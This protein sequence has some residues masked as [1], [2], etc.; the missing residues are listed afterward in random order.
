[1]LKCFEAGTDFPRYTHLQ[2][3]I[4]SDWLKALILVY[5]FL[6]QQHIAWS[7]FFFSLHSIGWLV[8]G[9]NGAEAPVAPWSVFILYM[10]RTDEGLESNVLI[11]PIKFLPELILVCFQWQHFFSPLN[12]FWLWFFFITRHDLDG[13]IQLRRF[14]DEGIRVDVPAILFEFCLSR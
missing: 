13:R 7:L 14:L 3:I 9:G 12:P 6:C 5:L 11:Q 8:S 1:M 10:C 2:V 4:Q